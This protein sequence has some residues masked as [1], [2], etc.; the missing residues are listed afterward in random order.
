M[1]SKWI[2]C[3]GYLGV[4]A[5]AAS[6]SHAAAT[7]GF[8]AMLDEKNSNTDSTGSVVFYDVDD[9]SHP[10][11]AVF[12]GFEANSEEVTSM[13]VDPNTG[14][15]YVVG[16]DSGVADGVTYDTELGGGQDGIGDLDLYKI[17]FQGAY[18]HWAANYQGAGAGGS[19]VY[20]T[21][22]R[23]ALSELNLTNYQ[24]A[25]PYFTTKI[26]EVARSA[27]QSGVYF[28]GRLEFYDENTLIWLDAPTADTGADGTDVRVKAFT[29]VSTSPGAA[30]WTSGSEEGG[31]NFSSS[32]ESWE[33]V[34]LGELHLDFGG[35]ASDMGAGNSDTAMV[36]NQN[37]VTG[38]W[39]VE[40]DGTG[41]DIAF[42][43]I[44]NFTGTAG[45][46]LREF[47]IEFDPINNPGEY[48]D[49]LA[50]DQ[51]PSVDPS[52]NDGDV[53]RIFVD[54]NGNLV[55]T[56]SGYFDDPQTEPSVQVLNIVS[57]DDGN[58]RIEL[59][60][61]NANI[62]MDM[63]GLTD[64]DSLVTDE[65]MSILDTYNNVL[66]VYDSDTPTDGGSYDQDWYMI[67]LN[68]GVTS[69]VTLNVDNIVSYSFGDD[70]SEYFCLGCT[71]ALDGDLN[72]D[73]FVGLDDL[74]I[75][76]GNWNQNVTA[77][78]LLQ[79]DPSG[80]GFVGLDD[81]DVVLNNW[82]AGTPPAASVV[83]EP[84]SL[85]LFTIAGLSALARRRSNA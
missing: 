67:D 2:A 63:T 53:R 60:T 1:N 3:L 55:M 14:D 39:V 71:V 36:I 4:T 6:A 45:N 34:L 76:L 15:V 49:T 42:F 51:N 64:D 61:W 26:G 17:D 79:G 80:D 73:G 19:D 10:L 56:E 59:G 25:G 74:D 82:N 21:Y 41:D 5:L 47:N 27:G 83:P 12:L 38:I 43:E 40:D 30:T 77:G 8:I 33:S 68:T 16:F 20:V 75:V 84:A 50:A 11:F 85:A 62:L 70:T 18:D 37:G 44:T 54:A 32:T 58:G 23:S 9:L 65:R 48:L 24:T 31:F 81:L 13:T 72:G 7:G 66:Y 28:D 52:T 46:G 22:G 78:D 57:M 35:S 69:F 29:R